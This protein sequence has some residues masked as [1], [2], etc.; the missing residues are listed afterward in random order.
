MSNHSYNHDDT[1]RRSYCPAI[2]ACADNCDLITE[3]TKHHVL[4]VCPDGYIFNVESQ[5]CLHTSFFK[6][7]PLKKLDNNKVCPKG[8]I[9][10]LESGECVPLDQVETCQL[11]WNRGEDQEIDNQVQK[12]MK[13][14]KECKMCPQSGDVSIVDEFSSC[15][16]D[17]HCPGEQIC[18]KNQGKCT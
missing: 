7:S 10:C 3:N 6:K 4:L 11:E 14:Q 5:S 12:C 17:F 16:I 18:C 2:N 9:F 15:I 8:H 13:N 1:G